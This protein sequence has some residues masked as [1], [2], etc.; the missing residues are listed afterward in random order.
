MNFAHAP[1]S[2]H[3]PGQFRY[4]PLAGIVGRVVRFSEVF[5]CSATGTGTIEHLI[6]IKQA[7][8]PA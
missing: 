6:H 7:V 3:A 1:A 4:A 5:E 8:V 2:R